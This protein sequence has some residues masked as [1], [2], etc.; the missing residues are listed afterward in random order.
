MP[1]SFLLVLN[2]NYSVT[3]LV[4]FKHLFLIIIYVCLDIFCIYNMFIVPDEC[5]DSCFNVRYICVICNKRKTQDLGFGFQKNS[6][7]ELF[8]IFSPF[9]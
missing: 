5:C 1:W 3:R 7:I 2:L 6:N 9:Y 8:T 4:L